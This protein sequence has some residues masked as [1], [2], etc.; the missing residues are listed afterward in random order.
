M[1]IVA[2]NGGW[3]DGFISNRTNTSQIIMGFG[4]SSTQDAGAA[5]CSGVCRWWNASCRVGPMST[6]GTLA[7]CVQQTTPTTECVPSRLCTPGSDTDT[8]A[9]RERCILCRQTARDG[10]QAPSKE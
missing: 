9:T 3:R 1:L 6:H 5:E 2:H 8:H 7:A 4:V 10:T